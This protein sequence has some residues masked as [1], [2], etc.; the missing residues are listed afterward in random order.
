MARSQ[1]IYVVRDD[2]ERALATFTVKHE[3]ITWLRSQPF[4]PTLSVWRYSDGV[5][6]DAP[7]CMGTVLAVL[8]GA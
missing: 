7:V 6:R 5:Y 1:Y 3:M 4:D 8:N 2:Y